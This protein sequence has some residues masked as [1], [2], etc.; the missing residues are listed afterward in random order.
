M[1]SNSWEAL[2]KGNFIHVTIVH[3]VVDQS[4]DT[5]ALFNSKPN[6]FYG[7]RKGLIGDTFEH[8]NR[9]STTCSTYNFEFQGQIW[10]VESAVDRLKDIFVNNNC[11][12]Q[13]CFFIFGN[14]T[15]KRLGVIKFH[16]QRLPGIVNGTQF[17][18]K[19]TTV[20]HFNKNHFYNYV[21]S[22][23][24]MKIAQP[25]IKYVYQNKWLNQF[26]PVIA[27][28][29]AAYIWDGKDMY[30]N[31]S[32]IKQDNVITDYLVKGV[33]IDLECAKCFITSKMIAQGYFLWD[34]ICL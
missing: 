16:D 22:E 15:D 18:S 5:H 23:K 30:T 7:I 25:I 33:H 17:I 27:F 34:K 24:R 10:D 2:K 13:D 3:G 9:H 1:N 6:P 8:G 32:L 26:P 20:Y 28:L 4:Y 12:F 21:A 19:K 29:I 11:Y 31:Y 14:W